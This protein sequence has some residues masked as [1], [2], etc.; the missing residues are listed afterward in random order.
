MTQADSK[1]GRKTC[2]EEPVKFRKRKLTKG[3]ND[4][5]RISIALKYDFI[6][7]C[8]WFIKYDKNTYCVSIDSS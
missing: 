8:F 5:S 1:R 4:G 6:T 3:E 7:V 2:P